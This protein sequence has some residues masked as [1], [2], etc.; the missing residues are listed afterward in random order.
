MFRGCLVALVTPFRDGRLDLHALDALVDRLIDA[1]VDGLVPC[2]TTGES[3]TLGDEEHAAIVSA[4]ARR[5]RGRAAV[6]AGAGTNSTAHTVHLARAARAAGADGIML[7]S[8]YYNRPTQEGLFQHF[9]TVARQTG[10]PIMLYNIPGRTGVEIAAPTIARLRA[11]CPDIAAVKHATGQVDGVSELAELCDIA[12]LSGD[13]PLTLP[14]LSVG[15]VGA[16]SV[17]AN[18]APADVRA[19][20][21]AALRG[22][23]PAALRLHRRTYAI[24][25]SLLSIA[26]NPI[27]IKTALALRGEM[28]EEFRLPMCPL[29]SDARRRLAEAI[30]A[31]EGAAR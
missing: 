19:M 7:V 23:W 1:K 12:I 10:G 20:I 2:G 5:A 8:P 29:G 18:Y 24:S 13:D 9:S 4:V 16:V 3:P 31:Y 26:T 21:D 15:A 6:I 11:E 27:P 28:A 14:M 30:A 25:K 22:D 17:L